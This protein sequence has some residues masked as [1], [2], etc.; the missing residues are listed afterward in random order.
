MYSFHWD[1]VR[2]LSLAKDN[3][4]PIP[5]LML[6]FLVEVR[7]RASALQETIRRVIRPAVSLHV[8]VFQRLFATS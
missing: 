6:I 2:R 1:M 5:A 7:I 3:G 4:K 8:D